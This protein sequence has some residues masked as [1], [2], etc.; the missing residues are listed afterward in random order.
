MGD[1]KPCETLSTTRRCALFAATERSAYELAS[2]L[3]LSSTAKVSGRFR[4]GVDDLQLRE[5]GHALF[6]EFDAQSPGMTHA[7]AFSRWRLSL[8]HPE[9]SRFDRAGYEAR[10]N[11]VRALFLSLARAGKS[12][13]PIEL[14]NPTLLRRARSRNDRSG[15]SP[16][17]SM[18]E[19]E[20]YRQSRDLP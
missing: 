18:I 16:A 7:G 2:Q 15:P 11:R 17:R 19:S 5:L 13:R 4:R 12:I 6:G 14:I 20:P 3:R 9:T 10:S 1:A 8:Q